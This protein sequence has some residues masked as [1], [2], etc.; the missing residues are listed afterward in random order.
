MTD[1]IASFTQTNNLINSSLRLQSNYAE[2]QIQVSSG[3]KSTD[4]AGI[5]KSSTRLLNLESDVARIDQQ[6]ENAQIA[7]D[8]TNLMFS[9]LEAILEQSQ[10][11]AADLSASVSGFGSEG[12]DLANIAQSNMNQIASSLNVQ[13]SDRYLFGGS[14]TQTRPIDLSGYGGQV[15][16]LPGTSTA[17]TSFYQGNSYLQNVE[18]ADGFVVNY[19]VL[20]DNPAFEKMIRGYDLIRTNPNDQDTLEEA[21]RIIEEAVDDLAVLKA[22]V[23]QNAQSLNRQI[24]ENKEEINLLDSQI[25]TIREVDVAEASVRLKQLETQLEASYTITAAL[26]NLKLSDFI[27]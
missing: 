11:F 13:I 19:G 27:R 9:S 18:S 17:D 7:L 4:Y 20:A 25:V 16:S 21:N 14:A 15:F 10:S 5:A 2:K 3:Y 22:S 6:T 26:L 8:R 23:S 1:R 24:V 12:A